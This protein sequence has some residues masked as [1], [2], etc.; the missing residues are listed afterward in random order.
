MY[1]QLNLKAIASQCPECIN[2]L[3]FPL[4]IYKQSMQIAL[5]KKM[6]RICIT[7]YATAAAVER[8]SEHGLTYH[9][10]DAH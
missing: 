1:E 6:K 5:D 8:Q 7:W 3:P 9:D 10:T 2:C 4:R